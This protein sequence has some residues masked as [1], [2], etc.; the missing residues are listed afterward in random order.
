[1]GDER[2]EPREGSPNSMGVIRVIV[3]SGDANLSCEIGEA[4]DS[5]SDGLAVFPSSFEA[6]RSSDK[7]V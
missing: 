4:R 5:R 2:E 3:S 1:M 6:N 7:V